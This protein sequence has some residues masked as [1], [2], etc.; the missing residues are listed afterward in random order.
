M[1]EASRIEGQLIT[2]ESELSGLKANLTDDNPRVRAVRA[3]IDV[4]Q[5]QLRKLSGEGETAD[6]SD[7]KTDEMLP[8]VRK[9]PLLG[10]TYYDLYR[11]VAMEETIYETLT[12]QYELAKV[13]EA[14]EV[15]PIKVLDEPV[16][17]EKKSYPH[18]L[19]MVILGTWIGAM[20]GIAWIIG[21][22]WWKIADDSHPVKA[23]GTTLVRLI[24]HR[25]ASIA[26]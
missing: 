11:Q 2:A 20:A 15:P 25:D 1:E 13:Q 19:T 12:K 5:S 4:L 18:R 23:L 9:L 26:N 3:R 21:R 16:P 24:R 17:A 6:G 10:V 22:K 7:L 8:S 14:K